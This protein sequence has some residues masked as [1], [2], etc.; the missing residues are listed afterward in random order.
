MQKNTNDILAMPSIG[1]IVKDSDWA[2]LFE[3]GNFSELILPLELTR[4][5]LAAKKI[6]L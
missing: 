5:C 6:R 1:E 2:Y 3:P 4:L